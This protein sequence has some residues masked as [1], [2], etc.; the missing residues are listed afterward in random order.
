MWFFK[1]YGNDKHYLLTQ[2]K[3]INYD[4]GKQNFKG[5]GL[6]T[7]ASVENNISAELRTLPMFLAK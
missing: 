2:E 7:R 5:C 3:T 6:K 1:Y 4:L